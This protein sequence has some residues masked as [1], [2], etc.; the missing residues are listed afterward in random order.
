LSQQ[1]L[2][3]ECCVG[4]LTDANMPDSLAASATPSEI[5][6]KC[7]TISTV[8]QLVEYVMKFASRADTITKAQVRY[9]H[10]STITAW[11]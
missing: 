9:P 3:R 8:Q 5:A 4:T 7:D 10:N 6:A 1:R 11:N 2:M